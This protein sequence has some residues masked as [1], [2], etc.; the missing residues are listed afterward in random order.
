MRSEDGRV[1]GAAAPCRRELRQDGGGGTMNPEA[2]VLAKL[3]EPI[4]LFH[5]DETFF[6]IDPKL[7][8]ERSALWRSKPHVR[9]FYPG[10]AAAE[11]QDWGEL[12]PTIFPRKP[13]LAKGT[14]AALQNETDGKTWIGDPALGAV[15]P[16]P[17]T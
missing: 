15:I 8:L 13:K 10:G 9:I 1:R 14:L 4:L 5:A 3:F 16:E 17:P 7:Y 6:P 2:A 12:P 11:K